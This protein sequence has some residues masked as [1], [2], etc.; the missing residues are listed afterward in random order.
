M[1]RSA[2]QALARLESVLATYD[3]ESGRAKQALV[4]QLAVDSVASSDAVLRLHEALCFLRAYP[5]DED[6]LRDVETALAGFAER[7][8]VRRFRASLEDTGVA[9]TAI[10]YRFFSPTARWLARTWPEL[11]SISWEEWDNR[12]HLLD[13]LPHALPYT[14]TLAL[15][16]VERTERE[17]IEEL[18]GDTAD[19]AFLIGRLG[20]LAGSEFTRE[21]TYDLLDVPLRLEPAANTPARGS[22]VFPVTDI[23]C[24][25]TPLRRSRPDLRQDV[26][27]PPVS[28]EPL[29]RARGQRLVDLARRAM[30]TRARDLDGFAHANPDDA[31]W[32][33]CG[34]GLAFGLLGLRPQRRLMLESSYAAVTL[35]NGVPMGYVL[36]SALYGSAAI[37]YNIF[38]TFRGAEAARVFGRVLAMARAVFGCDT[39]SIDPYQL[40]YGNAEGLASGAWWFYYKLG[41]RPRSAYVKRLVRDETRAMK[42]DPGHRTALGTLEELASENLYFQLD[43]PRDDVIGEIALGEIGLAMSRWLAQHYGA[44]RERGLRECSARAAELLEVDTHDFSPAQRLWWARWSPIVCAVDA[45]TWSKRDRRK[46]AAVVLAKGGRHES[47]F[48]PL[49][50]AH[51]RLKED[52][53][54][55][56]RKTSR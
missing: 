33:D 49:F 23:A 27:R 21:K 9:G 30:V 19:A 17:W 55:L 34:D 26:L 43:A 37:A 22:D 3:P 36:I 11:L 14:E 12:A 4:Q 40:G 41:F 13:V 6:L 52:L 35:K 10:N 29:S 50:D 51:T 18:R 24:Q 25:R 48:A 44:D 16:E 2:R 53:L 39:F 15:D 31:R 45:A 54:A 47:D 56:G 7:S 32:V 42:R 38:E 5:D 20:Q 28:I 8:D 46:L 1:K